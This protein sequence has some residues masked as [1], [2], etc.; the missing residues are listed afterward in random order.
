MF[1]YVFRAVCLVSSLVFVLM[2][3]LVG[4]ALY[5]EGRDM[6]LRQI[7]LYVALPA[8][9]IF[10]VMFFLSGVAAQKATNRIA[11][12]LNRISPDK[13]PEEVFPEVKP[14]LSNMRDKQAAFGRKQ[15]EFTQAT[16]YMTEGL[17]LLNSQG[18]VLSIND[19]ARRI[20]RLDA[21]SEGRDMLLLCPFDTLRLMMDDARAGRRSEGNLTVRNIAY[22]VNASPVYQGGHVVGIVL[23]LFD[24][25]QKEQAE[26]MRR[27]FTAN[28]SHELKTPLQT[29]SGCA[30]LLK[31]GMVKDEDVPRF[32]SQ[33]HGE[34]QRM[35]A[36]VEDII[37]LSR[38][39]EGNDGMQWEEIDLY[40]I[41]CQV[42]KV[43]GPAAENAGITFSLTG[44]SCKMTG[45]HQ[46]VETIVYNLCDNA[47]KYNKEKGMVQVEV[48]KDG[49]GARLTVSDTGIGIPIH[50][51]ERVFERFYR[52]DKSHSKEVG[53]TGLGLS[54][55]KH[56][57][58]LHRARIRLKSEVGRGT[59][60]T[61]TFPGLK[62]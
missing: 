25:T 9:G 20:F 28:V 26:K 43:L 38:L 16:R 44:E 59:R 24:V 52:V 50:Q 35:I 1:K 62:I 45:I 29:I 36:L 31:S 57:A 37:K 12:P 5:L 46:L 23:L 4:F 30:E 60:V 19:A 47:I 32:S 21:P 10:G 40:A 53:G 2:T 18:K 56:A 51:Q 48:K 41:A 22:Q 54:I 17:I 27:E 34:A 14:L 8:C 42:E 6:A 61:V 15:E 55:V 33:I 7:L 13:P 49:E 58:R 3:A 11:E 39:D